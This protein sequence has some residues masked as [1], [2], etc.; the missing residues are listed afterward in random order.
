MAG[1]FSCQGEASPK[2]LEMAG[3]MPEPPPWL[4]DAPAA[5]GHPDEADIEVL[6]HEIAQLWT[7]KNED[8]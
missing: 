1:T 3:A 4:A 8:Q 5:K 6:K 7:T 2:I